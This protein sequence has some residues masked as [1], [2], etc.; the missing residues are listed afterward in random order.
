M[1]RVAN[2]AVVRV[3]RGRDDGVLWLLPCFV[4]DAPGKLGM[5]RRLEYVQRSCFGP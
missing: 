5:R 1:L 2:L 4:E 3:I